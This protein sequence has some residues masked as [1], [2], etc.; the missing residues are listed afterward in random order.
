[1]K[2]TV[3][4]LLARSQADRT[5]AGIQQ[6]HKLLVPLRIKRALHEINDH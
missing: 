3:S 1:M 5:R 2:R 6:P 4:G